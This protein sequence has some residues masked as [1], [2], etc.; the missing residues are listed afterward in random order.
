MKVI[1]MNEEMYKVFLWII[2]VISST[3]AVTLAF[4]YLMDNNRELS[5]PDNMIMII[6]ITLGLIL[7][8]FFFKLALL[9][10]DKYDK[11]K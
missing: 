3:I 4:Y 1:I 9:K 10:D 6:I 5:N 2:T 8:G 11:E 7:M